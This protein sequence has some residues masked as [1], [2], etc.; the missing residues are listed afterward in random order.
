MPQRRILGEIDGNVPVRRELTVNQRTL[1]V[2]AKDGGESIREIAER[3]Q[4]PVSTVKTTLLR[5]RTRINNE[6]KPRAG[7]PSKWTARDRSTILRYVRRHPKS[8]YAQ[9]RAAVLNPPSRRALHRILEEQGIKKWMCKRRP[10]LTSQVANKRQA[11][12]SERK[13]WSVKE[14]RHIIF[15][16]ESSIE[17]GAG[18]QRQWVWRTPQ[19]KWSTPHLQTYKKGKDLSVMVWGA[20]WLGGRSDLV[21]MD[22]DEEAKRSGFSANS[23][24]DVLEKTVESCW[25]PGM[26]FMQDNAPIHKAKKVMQWFEDHGIPLLDWPPYSPD[27]N[28]IE[29]VWAKMKEWLCEQYPDARNWGSSQSA[30]NMLGRV[31][32]EAWEAIPQEFIDGLINTMI[33]RVTALVKAEGWHTKY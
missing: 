27:M 32:N 10:E 9:L 13:D 12:A 31:I 25:S 30:L 1:I 7:R 3:L 24:L 21:I 20:I 19:Q 29:H 2:G 5:Q 6:S 18:G 22:I 33:S 14:W 23:Y 4:I 11:W 26:T 16:D 15:S 28:P 17:R 8:T